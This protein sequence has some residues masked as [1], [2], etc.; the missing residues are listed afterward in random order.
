MSTQDRKKQRKKAARIKATRHS[1]RSK[2]KNFLKNGDYEK[3]EI[4]AE[5]KVDGTV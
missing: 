2:I 5:E 3:L 1:L 4:V